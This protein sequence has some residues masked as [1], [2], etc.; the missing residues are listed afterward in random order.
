V[1]DGRLRHSL[2]VFCFLSARHSRTRLQYHHARLAVAIVAG[3][4]KV[5][6]RAV[7]LGGERS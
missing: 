6:N 7:Q 4:A 3:A 5:Q 2:A 1:G